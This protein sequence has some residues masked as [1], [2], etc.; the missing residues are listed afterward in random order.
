MGRL[1]NPKGDLFCVT[2]VFREVD[3]KI[4]LPTAL[5]LCAHSDQEDIIFGVPVRRSANEEINTVHT[6]SVGMAETQVA[7][8]DP[9]NKRLVLRS[10]HQLCAL[11][12]TI[13]LRSL[14]FG[15]PI[16]SRC[17]LLSCATIRNAV[18]E[19]FLKGRSTDGFVS[20]L[21]KKGMF[22]KLTICKGCSGEIHEC[23]EKAR[24]TVWEKI[25]EI[26]GL[27]SWEEIRK[28]KLDNT[29]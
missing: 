9:L 19:S 29:T 8:L 23:I 2:N 13:T 14:Y 18:A 12:R 24:V 5:L 6:N 11:A 27:G 26:Y 3:A 10:R 21:M 16:Q 1:G 25:P 20:P 15:G 17:T 7:E 22:E 4:L 28:A